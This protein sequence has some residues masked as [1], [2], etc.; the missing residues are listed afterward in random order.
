MNIR[1]LVGILLCLSLGSCGPVISQ[2]ILSQADCSLSFEEL[3]S[4]PDTWRGQ[5][6]VL[7]GE[8]MA[9]TYADS[10]S[11]LWVSQQQLGPKFRPL[12]NS[13]SGGQFVVH[14]PQYLNTS[15]YVKNR[16]VTVAGTVSGQKDK[17]LLLIPKQIYLWEYPFELYTVPPEWFRP[18]YKHWY[19]PPYFD[20]YIHSF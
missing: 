16:K 13:P 17:A 20:P 6:V 7:G 9:V 12:D 14:S 11:W 1:A 2:S 3:Q 10:G 19:E 4:H 8:V 5:V 15:Y 18:P